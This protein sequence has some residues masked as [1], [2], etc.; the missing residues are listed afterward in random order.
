MLYPVNVLA[1]T[2][3]LGALGLMG[4]TR[5]SFYSRVEL[6]NCLA[7]AASVTMVFWLTKLAT[8]SLRLALC[9]AAGLGFS[10]AFLLHATNS[11]E[12][13]VGIFWSFLAVCLAALSFKTG[14]KWPIIASGFLFALAMATYQSTIFLAPAAIVVIWYGRAPEQGQSFF[15][16]PRLSLLS[17]FPLACLSGFFFFS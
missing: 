3:L 13:M 15:S 14:H 9:V 4:E 2:R 10:K 16:R 8:R 11:A 1:W 5:Q 12:P 17:Q 7:A 6:M